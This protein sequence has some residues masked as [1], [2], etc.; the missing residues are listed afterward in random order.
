MDRGQTR[1]V[2]EEKAVKAG[3][4]RRPALNE[5]IAHFR[6]LRMWLPVEANVIAL[7]VLPECS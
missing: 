5:S 3:V 4:V 1:P 7:S 6:L 2:V